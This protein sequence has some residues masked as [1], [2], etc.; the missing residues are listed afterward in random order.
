MKITPVQPRSDYANKSHIG[1]GIKYRVE[2]INDEFVPIVNNKLYPF[3]A[4]DSRMEALQ[5]AR[6]KAS[7][8]ATEYMMRGVRAYVTHVGG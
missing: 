2:E 6:R 7:Q 8:V 1:K 4:R 5:N 3:L